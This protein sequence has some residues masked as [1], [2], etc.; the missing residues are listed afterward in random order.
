MLITFNSVSFAY[1][2]NT[3]LQDI[4]FSVNEGERVGLIGENGA[5]KTTLLKLICG[6]LEAESGEVI[7]KNGIAVGFLA[8]NGGL[9]AEGTAYSQM[10]EAV[11]P[12]LDAVARLSEISR[13][14]SDAEYGGEQYKVLSAKYESLEKY[15]AAH[16]CYNA[17]VRVKTVLSGMG[18]AGLYEQKISTMSGG[19]KTR[20]KLARLL[21]EEPDLLI[22]DEPTNHLDIKTLFWLEDY[23]AS[24]KGAVIVVSHDRY[25]LDRV[26]RRILE[27]ENKKLYSYPGNYSKY[28]VL[29]AERI[30]L[31]QKE[32]ERQQEERAKLQDY[33]DRNLVRATTAKSAQSRVK[34]LEKMELLEKPYTPPAPPRFKFTFPAQSAELVLNVHGLNLE[35]GGKKLISD[36]EMQVMRGRRVAIVGENGAGKST[37]LKLIARGGNASCVL[38]RFVRIAYYDQENLNL[39]TENTVL[40]ELWERHVSSSQTDVRAELARCGLSAEDMYKKVGDL[41][42]GERAKLAL[43]VM[44]SEEG[45]LLL[46]DEPTNHLDLPARESLEKAIKQFEGTVIFVS[47]D[48]YF[49]AA[50]ADG[51]AEIEGG[52]LNFVQGGYEAFRA[53]KAELA[54]R[55]EEGEAAR[56]QAE[57]AERK[58]AGYRSKKERAAEAAA[59]ARI[60]QIEAEISLGES[61]EAE[62]QQQLADPAVT[63]DYKQVEQLCRRLEEI[64]TRQEELY[65]EYEKLI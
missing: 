57:Y 41:S 12:Q 60:K 42:G 26:S 11:K 37:L 10:L 54:R 16:D 29:K 40:A 43:C 55:L 9:E 23:L 31:E 58:A 34:Q 59:K 38:G 3:I 6:P 13:S 21:L 44:E 46:L 62:I 24:F 51:I 61:E 52:K 4:N 5:G 65:S 30:A 50:L 25:F 32:Y 48:R 8:Q 36:G 33:V 39:N 17:E 7:K 47:H 49:I 28:K 14:L 1:A 27:I 53:Q 22:L 18:F 56:R 35:I 63:A 2:G 20:L 45:N 15:I 19:E 64:K